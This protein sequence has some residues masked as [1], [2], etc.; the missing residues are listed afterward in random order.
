MEILETFR[1]VGNFL[2]SSF[3]PIY[4]NFWTSLPTT[5]RSCLTPVWSRIQV[6][7][8]QYEVLLIQNIETQFLAQDIYVWTRLDTTKMRLF[9]T[10]SHTKSPPIQGDLAIFSRNI[11]LTIIIIFVWTRSDVSHVNDCELGTEL[12]WIE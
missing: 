5:K 9:L 3:I 6:E 11:I 8:F 7:S 4:W 12:R 2:V 1:E 10:T